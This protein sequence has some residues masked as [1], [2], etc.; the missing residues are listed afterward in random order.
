MEINSRQQLENDYELYF[1]TKNNKVYTNI[2]EGTNVEV[3]FGN[4]FK[5]G[6][7]LYIYAY[8]ENIQSYIL[9]DTKEYKDYYVS[10]K[11]VN[12]FEYLVTNKKVA[13][14]L[15]YKK[16]NTP[17]SEL[18]F[19]IVF[20]VVVMWTIVTLFKNKIKKQY[21]KESSKETTEVPVI[22]NAIEETTKVEEA[23]KVEATTEEKNESSNEVI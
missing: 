14:N 19:V 17:L 6:E 2:F 5:I 4:Q 10:F 16:K 12:T 15:V 8:D 11:A 20:Q 13:T 22:T 9:I 21:E 18:I 3:Y 23:P 1:I 7:K